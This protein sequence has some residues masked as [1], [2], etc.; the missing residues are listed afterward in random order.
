MKI[1]NK[2]GEWESKSSVQKSR[3]KGRTGKHDH[4]RQIYIS[5]TKGGMGNE[6]DL[7]VGRIRASVGKLEMGGGNECGEVMPEFLAHISQYGSP[8][9]LNSG[10]QHTSNNNIHLISTSKVVAVP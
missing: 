9:Y 5:I 7:V 2:Y 4:S 10:K 6:F 1:V 8:A 3:T